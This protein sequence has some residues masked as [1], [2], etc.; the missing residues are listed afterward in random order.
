M[1]PYHIPPTPIA[2][3]TCRGTEGTLRE[4]LQDILPPKSGRQ[5][6]TVGFRAK[7]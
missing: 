3:A 2:H 4:L 7:I 6:K 1:M 5:L